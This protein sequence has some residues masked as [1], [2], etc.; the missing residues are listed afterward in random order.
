MHTSVVTRLAPTPSG[1]LHAGN[2]YN[3][4][5]NWL[6]ARAAGGR[7]LLR[8]DDLDAARVR[9]EYLDD[10]FRTLDW[11]GLDWDL[12]PTGVDDFKKNWSQ[13]L[14][15]DRYHQTLHRLAHM[16]LLF[17]CT[18]SRK[19]LQGAAVYPRVCNHKNIPLHAP[20]VAWRLAVDE[21]TH[22]PFTDAALGDVTFATGRL[23]GCAVMR[24]RDAVPAYHI[25]SLTDDVHFGVN[26]IVRG[27]DLLPSTALQ[28]HIASLLDEKGFLQTRFWHHALLADA[29]GNKLSKS[30]GSTSLRHLRENGY[31]SV[32][33][34]RDFAAWQG[35]EE[36][37]EV[38]GL[39]NLVQIWRQRATHP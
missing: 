36:A 11:L 13:T 1:Y 8:M 34:L 15:T 33:L 2:A 24:R 31:R 17:A 4:L 32:Q 20:D 3:F 10:V 28:L 23:A 19:T 16:G 18:C 26:H 30:A 22:T 6:T 35:I 5:M 21:E 39:Q 25:A 7:V 12:G 29:G 27:M 38:N 37:E 14:R 9:D